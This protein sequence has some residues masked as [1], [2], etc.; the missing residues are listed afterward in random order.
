MMNFIHARPQVTATVD[1][2]RVSLKL[3]LPL[4]AMILSGGATSAA[5]QSYGVADRPYL[6]WS[7]FSV[8]TVSSNFLTQTNIQ[9][10]SDAL[11]S[12]GLEHYGF[13]YINID[14]GWQG[15][16]DS[17]GRPAP[18]ASL[19]PDMAGLIAHIHSNGQKA[20]IYWTPGLA[21]QAVIANPQILGTAHHIG[22][23]LAVPN[24][25]GDA[26]AVSDPLSSLS[27]FKI[28]FSKEGAQEYINSVVDMF[29]SWGVDYIRLDGV[30]PGSSTLSVDNQPDVM[31]WGKA[32][33]QSHRPIWLTVSWAM[34]QDY[35][36][37][38]QQYTN[39]RRISADLECEGACSTLTNWSLTSQRWSDLLGWQS[40]AGP[41]AG[42]NDL[43]PLE[44]GNT[45]ADG[46]SA[47]EQQSAISLWAMANAPLYLGGDLTKLDATGIDL[48]TNDEVLAVDQ[49]GR[50]ATQIAGGMTPIWVSDLGDGS[51]Y[52]ALFNL[53]AFPSPVTIKWSTL[54]FTDAPNVRD[55]WNR[56]DLGRYDG[57]FSAL[58]L[59]HGVRLIRVF[60]H[61][62]A[63][64][65]IAQSYEAELG[66]THGQTAFT[67]CKPCSGGYEIIKL[68]LD[69]DNTV[70][71]DNIN[72]EHTGTY[73]MEIN[74]ATSGPR[75]LFYQVNDGIPT[76]LK[77]GGGS[78][79]LPST[80]IVPVTLVAGYNSIQ[81]GN[82]TGV[83]PDLDRIAII[84]EGGALAP[85]F[86]VYDAEIGTLS[87]TATHTACEYCSGNTK[88]IGLGEGSDNV[89]TFPDIPMNAA[90]MYQMEIDYLTKVPRFLSVTINDGDPIQ[91][92]L[93]GD[94]EELPTSVVIPVSLKGGKNTIQFGNQDSQAPAV[95]KIAIGPVSEPRN[96]TLGIRNQ[97]G[98][99][100]HRTWILD[101]A[102]SSYT[103]AEGAQLNQL[104]LVQ[105]SGQGSCQPTVL[106]SMPMTLGTIPK[107]KDVTLAVPID[108]TGCS[109]DAHFNVSIVYSSDRGA[110]VG[111]IIDTGLSQ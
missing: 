75:D 85:T 97:S 56:R 70:T 74:S 59:G 58:V 81:F 35:F 111:D 48:L 73:R 7:S 64:P 80:T 15:S 33:A 5:A 65:E 50:P 100:I 9:A 90:G 60:T 101:M 77:V 83:A 14:A 46:L 23:I 96:L 88:I 78:F 104:S 41:Q 24:S 40:Y 63:D 8:Q 25:A 6:G 99:P 36:T 72:V 89:V 28:D 105:V 93:A 54:G 57:N 51:F 16:F 26:F 22:D 27:N 103:P 17:N 91:L 95:D 43:G 19:F 62:A 12:S 18:N 92:N 38:W 2:H 67:I 1:Q 106:A 47:I 13:T 34:D 79:N 29:A 86:A 84:G 20:G 66:L 76:S 107:Q 3:L 45:L 71:L 32:I 10:Q 49:S 11:L 109:N 68:G 37:T 110:V 4:V 52:V 21:R 94:S 44:V 53:N 55:L 69:K 39:A 42:W 30:A 87:G 108:F 82:P 31:A 102:N 98:P 61:G